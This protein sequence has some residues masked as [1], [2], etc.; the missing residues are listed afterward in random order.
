MKKFFGRK[1][2]TLS[3]F[4]LFLIQNQLYA[5]NFR[6]RK[7]I[8]LPV[9]Q[10]QESQ[11]ISSGIEDAVF[12]ELPKDLTFV[13][14][15]ELNLKIPEVVATWRDSVAYI[16]YNGIEPQPSEKSQNYS[17]EKFFLKTLPS[18]LSLTLV[19]P[20]SSDFSVKDSPY[21]E[22]IP[23]LSDYS[24]GIFIRF[25]QVMKGVPEELER[26][27][28]EVSAKPILKNKGILALKTFP[29]VSEEKKYSV[30]VD[31]K[32]VQDWR[33]L[34]LETGEHHLSI[35][36]DAYRNELRT[37]RIE[38][39]K[40]TNLEVTLRGSEPTL[41]IIG[42]AS[43]T[44]SLDSQP[45]ANPKEPFVITTGEHVIKFTLGD[46]EVVKTLTAVTGRSYTVNL[47]IDASVSEEE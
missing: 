22:K 16:I 27:E 1:F 14:G 7:V 39:A 28:I 30:F 44:V 47:D 13:S 11:Q 40:T 6:V 38:Q 2:L 15:I 26:A 19:L 10:N 25:Q 42:P 46:Y 24:K 12:V 21:S 33:S 31:D 9:P 17:G 32:P 37:F 18:K 4:S 45:L 36:S 5:E 23:P 35:V 8:S 3:L 20:I 43:A 41:K 29:A 34:M